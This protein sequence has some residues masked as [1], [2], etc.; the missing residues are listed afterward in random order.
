MNSELTKEERARAAAAL[1]I[2][3]A[4]E[5]LNGAVA[6]AA[7]LSVYAKM[8]IYAPPTEDG[9]PRQTYSISIVDDIGSR[10]R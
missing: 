10:R 4:V 6:A 3:Q 7:E 2:A 1:A 9:K 5:A 8:S